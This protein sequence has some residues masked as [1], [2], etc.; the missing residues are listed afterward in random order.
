MCKWKATLFR[1]A[2]FTLRITSPCVRGAGHPDCPGVEQLLVVFFRENDV[3]TTRNG[4]THWN[5]DLA[6]CP[7]RCARLVRTGRHDKVACRS[8]TPGSG[9]TDMEML[10]EM[11]LLADYG[12][13]V[14]EGDYDT[15]EEGGMGFGVFV[16]GLT[17]GMVGLSDRG[18]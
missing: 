3:P 12:E 14:K 6:W 7:H 10:K 13:E 4:D 2:H 11:Y 16:A 18:V 8:Q 15:G 1:C 17:V 9:E 5:G